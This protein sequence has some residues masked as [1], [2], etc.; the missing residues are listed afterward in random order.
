[1]DSAVD[2]PHD[3]LGE[4]YDVKRELLPDEVLGIMDQLLC[5]EVWFICFLI[6]RG[7]L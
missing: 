6:L 4:L 5:H 2:D 1:M 3:E 7:P